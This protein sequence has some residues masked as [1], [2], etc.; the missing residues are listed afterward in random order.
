MN[1]INKKIT[2]HKLAY[3]SIAITVFFIAIRILLDGSVEVLPKILVGLGT[4]VLLKII[5]AMYHSKLSKIVCPN[6]GKPV[7]TRTAWF[8]QNQ[9][10]ISSYEK[11]YF[12]GTKF[13][14]N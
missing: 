5:N 4:L 8:D 10:F 12:C 14:D 2:K 7:M 1:R 3:T 9:H 11:C 6:C 13:D